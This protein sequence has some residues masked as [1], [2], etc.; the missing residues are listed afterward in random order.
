MPTI[1]GDDLLKGKVVSLVGWYIA[2]SYELSEVFDKSNG[3]SCSLLASSIGI[4]LP[5]LMHLEVF[6]VLFIAPMVVAQP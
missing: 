5:S 2:G 4:G 1:F 3:L 6:L